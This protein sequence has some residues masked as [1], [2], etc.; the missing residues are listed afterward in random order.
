MSKANWITVIGGAVITILP[1]IVASVP[2]ADK[3]LA[4]AVLAAILAAWHLYQ[5]SPS[6]PKASK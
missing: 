1:Q 3:A 4:S 5:P 6:D 2:E